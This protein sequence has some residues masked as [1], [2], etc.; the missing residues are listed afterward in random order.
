ME[1]RLGTFLGVYTPTILTI[2]G[3]IM[4]LRFGWLVGHLG[5]VQVLA[6]VLLAHV[7][8]ICTT[9][10]F[11]S[12]ATNGRVGAGG[13]YYIISR[14]LGLEIGG[15]IGLP[16]FLSQTFSVTLY[17]FGLAESLRFVWPDLPLQPVAAA[18]IVVVGAVSLFGAGAALRSQVVLMVVV[19]LSIVGFALGTILR[20]Q[21]S[22]VALSD[23][24]GEVSFW[25]GFAVFF[26][27][28]TGAMA[29]LGLSGD[30]R[31]PIRAIP[32]GS[33]LAVG[34]GLVLYLLIPIGLAVASPVEQL[35]TNA[36][37]WTTVAVGGAWIVLPGLWSAIFSSAV[38]SILGAPRTLQALARDGLAPR[39][40]AGGRDPRW[41]L[42]PGLVLSLVIA[43]VAVMLGNLNA[44]AA[45]VSMFFLTV[46][47][48]TN[49]VTAFETL[50][51]DPSWRPGLRVHWSIN[52][53][54]GLSCL[55]TMFLIA[56][57]AATLAIV[58]ELGL[59]LL[60]SRRERQAG[61]GDA[62]RGLYESLIRWALV[63][64]GERP[65]SQRNWRPHTM[66]FVQSLERD[67]DLVRYADWFSQ[68][69]GVVTVCQL[70]VGDLDE[71]RE[72]LPGRLDD[73]KAVL[74]EEELVAF[75]EI[76]IV[77]DVVD[78]IVS[79]AQANGM[80]GL[81]SNTVLLGWPSDPAL[82]EAFLRTQ[83]RLARLRKSLVI[84]RIKPR[85][86]FR[87]IGRQREIH[88]WWGGLQRN[89]D[90]MLLLAYL[91]SRNPEWRDA[92]VRILSVATTETMRSQ[93]QVFL[94]RML[95]VVRI[96]AEF[97]ILLKDPERKVRDMIQQ[98]SALADVVFL[99]LSATAV[100][101]EAAAAQRLDQLA[102]ELPCVF[103]VHNASVFTGD[104]LD[105]GEHEDVDQVVRAPLPGR[106]G[107]DEPPEGAESARRARG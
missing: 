34:T 48:T 2:L 41:E 17:S 54:G 8:T 12:V 29:G 85:H 1:K 61:W 105:G 30:L 106:T 37:V 27:A 53:L 7:I 42:L 104:L 93:T 89:G 38:G 16:L 4:Y 97:E 73:M 57:V 83:R 24:S 25:K 40:L 35:R 66:V 77:A 72:D 22:G 36:L 67:L 47:G 98:E 94:E 81:S 28:V 39:L 69:R 44:V 75:P 74:R 92:R 11:S 68:G 62:R 23:A 88:V 71:E 82:Q 80:A 99:G 70:L 78:G 49:L 10:S 56:P 52:L 107:G 63:R 58:C 102:G 32:R 101:Q 20:G 19:G 76:D 43:L 26:P 55:G 84:G 90:L 59:F 65:V 95:A 21:L 51:G 13:A 64:L 6:I 31:D 100:G 5:L 33:L 96:D 60:L 14:S 50:G 79:V 18:V 103:F 46:Y 91:L 45:V 3:V 86:Q 87:R 15:A 9:L